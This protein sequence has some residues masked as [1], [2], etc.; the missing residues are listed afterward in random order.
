MNQSK[1]SSLFETAFGTFIGFG[2]AMLVNWLAMPWLFGVQPTATSNFKYVVLFTIVSLIRGYF[3]RRMWNA[4]W[5][6][7]F[8]RKE[9]NELV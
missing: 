4:Q 6:K 5:W 1:I 2:L 9:S 3:V 8:S 7:K